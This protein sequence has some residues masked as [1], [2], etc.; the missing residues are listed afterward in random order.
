MLIYET[1]VNIIIIKDLVLIPF[2]AL[3]ILAAL[4]ITCIVS[5]FFLYF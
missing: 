3:L 1:L 4:P 2:H 5:V